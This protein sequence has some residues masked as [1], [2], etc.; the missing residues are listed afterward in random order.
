VALAAG[1]GALTVTE[2]SARHT[3]LLR[4]QR[5]SERTLADATNAACA[6]LAGWRSG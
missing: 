1:D 3:L 5:A 2:A 4:L 6:A